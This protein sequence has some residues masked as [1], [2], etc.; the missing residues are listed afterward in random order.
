MNYHPITD[1]LFHV[2]SHAIISGYPNETDKII[3][4]EIRDYV[5]QIDKLVRA[6]LQ[7]HN[8]VPDVE[9]VF[10]LSEIQKEC[11]HDWK[12]S[13]WESRP[14]KAIE[15]STCTKCGSTKNNEFLIKKTE[16][17]KEWYCPCS[18][19]YDRISCFCSECGQA[20]TVTK[21]IREELAEKLFKRHC[22]LPMMDVDAMLQIMADESIVFFKD[23]KEK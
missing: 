6:C 9:A 19:K 2:D 10:G 3:K 15:Y 18:P 23:L 7:G 8:I 1:K 22:E 21:S 12:N 13:G 4:D 20:R 14:G 17:K 11:E 5:Q 16:Q